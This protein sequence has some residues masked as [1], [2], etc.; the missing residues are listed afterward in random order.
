MYFRYVLI[1]KKANGTLRCSF[2]SISSNLQEN[3]FPPDT[4]LQVTPPKVAE[5]SVAVYKHY[6]ETALRGGFTPQPKDLAIY[7]KYASFK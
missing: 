7:Q 4:S 5:K 1:G 3:P 2:T 6:I